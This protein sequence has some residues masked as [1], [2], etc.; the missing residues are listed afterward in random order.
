[1]LRGEPQNSWTSASSVRLTPIHQ[2]DSV[3]QLHQVSR[4]SCP[5]LSVQ[6]LNAHGRRSV[7]RRRKE[8]AGGL[9]KPTTP[10]R[11]VYRFL[12]PD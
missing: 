2:V 7:P 9:L 8:R 6:P 1:M 4:L 3:D 5:F 12:V 10:Q 11:A